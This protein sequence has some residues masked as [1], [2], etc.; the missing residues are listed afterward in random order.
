MRIALTITTWVL[1]LLLSLTHLIDTPHT[2]L[3]A[4]CVT[5]LCLAWPE[6]MNSGPRLPVLPFHTHFGA[7]RDLSEL[8]W[9]AF[10]RDGRASARV[11]S[12]V[13]ALAED[14]PSLD[15]VRE[16]IDTSSSP[17]FTQILSWL[18]AIDAEKESHDHT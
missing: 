6:E 18:D 17:S 5:A 7:R 10:D 9:W 16:A 13:R 8:S 3:L 14:A 11:V 2:L 15:P 1:A 12:R 4:V